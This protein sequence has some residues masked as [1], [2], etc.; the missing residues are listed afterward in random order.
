AEPGT[1]PITTRVT[2]P[3]HALWRGV[4]GSLPGRSRSDAGSS[5]IATRAFPIGRREFPNRYPGVPDRTQGVPESLLGRSRPDAGRSRRRGE[6]PDDDP[7]ERHQP[8]RAWVL[9]PAG[10]DHAA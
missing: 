4:P 9:E 1:T 7:P 10:P 5:R 2:T 3:W 6:F 8:P